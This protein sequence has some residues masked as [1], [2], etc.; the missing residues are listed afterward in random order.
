[1]VSG[2]GT[3]IGYAIARTFAA[4]G[5]D[6]WILGRRAEVLRSAA[7]KINA[8]SGGHPVR[9][10]AADL[11]VPEQVEGAAA[12]VLRAGYPVDVLVNNAGGAT[13]FGPKSN[14]AEVADAW[15]REFDLNVLTAVLLT[16]AL[17]DRLRRP[18]GRVVTV[19]SIAALR[20]GAGAYSAA[21]AALH[22]WS[23][24]LA[25]ELGPDGITVN[26]VAP[27]YVAET[28]FFGDRMTAESHAARVKQTLVGRAGIPDDIAAAVRYLASPEAGYVTGQVL[29][30]NGG[31][32]LGQG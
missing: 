9:W 29:Q 1:V 4:E 15:R 13:S 32:L 5:D 6:V 8:E 22:G 19:S 20:G 24:D 27:G 2:G 26:V 21:K 30:V 3:G 23:Y 25:T 28:E 17:R 11:S 16:T 12:A 18:D 31:A 10:H 7:E 14:L